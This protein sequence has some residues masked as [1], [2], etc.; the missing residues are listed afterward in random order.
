M[1]GEGLTGALPRSPRILFAHRF[2]ELY[3]EAGNPTLRRVAA[4]AEHRMR[5][6]QGN[7]P[8][9]ASAQRIS[10]WKAGRNV[11]ARFE[12]LL[13]V[14]LTLTD[15]ARKAGNPLPRH[16]ADTKEWQRL[17]HAATTWNPE[18]ETEAACPYLGL[19][20]YRRENR[21][22]FFGRTRA[23]TELTTLV[24]QS[25]GIIA[26]VGASGAGKSS[27][28]AAGLIPALTDWEI[29][30]CTP[31]SHPYAALLT[32]L[33]YPPSESSGIE[34]PSPTAISG[35]ES[36]SPTAES[37]TGPKAAESVANTP[38]HSAES[39]A[40]TTDEAAPSEPRPGSADHALAPRADGPR[41]LVVID[42][43]EELFTTCTDERERELFLAIL[44]RC[45]RRTDDPVAVV[46]ALRAD[47]YAH[48]LNYLV[49]QDTLEHRNFLLGPMRTDELA[50]AVSGPARAAGLEL[51]PGLEEL[52]IT[53]LCGAGDHHG[54][55]T[56]DPGALPL[57]SH[58]MAATWQYREG[59]RLTVTGYRKAGGV[60]GSV[61]ETA[62]YAW[63]ELSSAQRSAAKDLLLG[64][65]TVS[66]DATDTRRAAPRADLLHRAGNPEDATAAL[67]LLSRTRLLTLDADSIT[68]THEIVLTA[69]PRLRTWIDEDRVGYLVRQRLETDAAEWAAQQ[70]DPTLL[71]RGT[72]LEN[73]RTHVDP[74]PVGLLAHEFLTA[75]ITARRTTKRRSSRTRAILALL[76]V[77]LLVVGFAA[78]TQTR[79][80]GQQRADET[81]AA[82]LAEA[83][84]VKLSDPSL[85]A[86]LYLVARQLRPHDDT[87]N[88]RLLQTQNLPLATATRGQDTG[89]T[90]LVF[91][92]DG[93]V[94]ASIDCKSTLRLWDTTDPHHPQPLGRPIDHVSNIAFSPDDRLMATTAAGEPLGLWD[95][96]APA[97]PREVASMPAAFPPRLA[98]V[99]F[100]GNGHL[101][102]VLWPDRLD[103]WNVSNPATPVLGTSVPVPAGPAATDGDNI[104]LT[105]LRSSPDG[106]TL[107]IAQHGMSG[108]QHPQPSSVQL[109]HVDDAAPPILLHRFDIDGDIRDLAFSADGRMLAIGGGEATVR[110][111][112]HASAT[113][114][115]WNVSD[116]VRTQ[117]IGTTFAVG[118]GGLETLAFSTDDRTLATT[119]LSF[120]TL[121]NISEPAYP[122]LITGSLSVGGASCRF[123]D[124]TIPGCPTAARIAFQPGGDVL[125]AGGFDG[126]LYSWWLPPAVLT[127]HAG[128]IAP[129]VFDAT[130][131]RMVTASGDGRITIWGDIRTGR[132][133]ARLGEY[134]IESGLFSLLLSPDA[135]TLVVLTSLPS[136]ARALDISDPV[137]IK[138][139]GGWPIGDSGSAVAFDLSPDWRTLAVNRGDRTTQLYDFSNRDHPIPLGTPLPMRTTT[140]WPAFSPDSRNLLMQQFISPGVNGSTM[141]YER[142]DLSDRTHPRKLPDLLTYQTDVGQPARYTPDFHTMVVLSNETVHSW[143]ISD[144]DHPRELGGPVALSAD[145]IDGVSFTSDSRTLLASDSDGT[146]Q[147]WDFIDPAHPRKLGGSLSSDPR[148]WWATYVPGDQAVV[149]TTEDGTLRWWDL[150]VQHAVDR[151]CSATGNLWTVAL[152]KQHLPQLD[153]RPPCR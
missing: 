130:G 60:V 8:G 79:L 23:T 7:R 48:C 18:E 16:L 106:R 114:T 104:A 91:R 100:T 71:Y 28:L 27:L 88:S 70:R 26:L 39:V 58:V 122:S 144:L 32:A 11:P 112:G 80:V 89:I 33:G 55:R 69:W 22:L 87:V 42:Q 44:D 95:V 57:L 108:S 68:L 90:R 127:G 93:R 34:S 113:V 78:Y 116:P 54:R 131:N 45:A 67:E 21:A 140:A 77:F 136:S 9:G 15:L 109:W 141:V 64:L 151:I 92:G 63:N 51:E 30:T 110:P 46:L 105:T 38:E 82:V 5:A 10:D 40:D 103:Q 76:G 152:W 66:Q 17:W 61:A 149:A 129:P 148:T 120:T 3:E 62:E 145:S 98:D 99:A 73:A 49:L 86:Q 133:P 147:R 97:E 35:A 52:V 29:T 135:R 123:G 85:A 125:L 111:V 43:F 124:V 74:P 83:A 142:W 126:D 107:A 146:V 81:F 94:V 59:R 72:R 56:Y 101:L 31:G 2:T 75:A 65:V 138:A 24:R 115:L 37:G 13:P 118:D 134:R 6:A 36:Q 4:A 119:G 47:F 12:S 150:D 121:W 132:A 53:E 143:D 1:S 96:T 102:T 139:L 25:T 19:G 50:Q 137:H 84:R 14:V 128:H 41:R 153:Y 20:S 117:R